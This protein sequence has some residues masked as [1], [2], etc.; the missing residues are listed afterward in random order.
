MS[1]PWL[2]VIGALP[3]LGSI[4]VAAL[5]RTST[6]LAKR[7]ALVVS[8]V[9]LALTVVMAL[10]FRLD[11]P[12]F[13]FVEDYP[14][15]PEFGVRYALGVDGVGLILIGLTV[16]LT[17][18]AIVAAWREKGAAGGKDAPSVKGYFALILALE[19]AVIGVFAATD[20]FVFYV[21]FEVM[22]VP[23][24]FMIGRYGGERRQYAAVK[25]FLYSLFGGM[26]MLASVIALA[27]NA[28]QQGH[29]TFA[30][31]ELT[32]LELSQTT[33]I[34]LFL[35]FFIAFAIKASLWPFHTWLPDAASEA[36][37][38]SA[39]LL[40]GVMDPAGAFGMIRYGLELFPDAAHFFTP[41]VIVLAVV[42]VLYGALAAIGQKNILRLLAY[43]SVSHFG[44]IVLG[45]FAMTSQSQTGAMFYLVTAGV[46]VAI[47]FLLAGVM[48]AR[49]G[50]RQIDDYGGVVKVAPVLGGTFLVA[51]LAGLALPGLATFVSEFL[52]LVGTFARYPVPAIIATFGIV[53]AAVYMLWLYQRTMTG[54]AGPKVSTIRDLGRREKAAVAPLI[55]LLLFLGLFPKP[56]LDVIDPAVQ[57]TMTRLDIQDVSAEG[58]NP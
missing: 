42:G 45:I 53:L 14:W 56:V 34:W 43:T 1:F 32:K 12:R 9:V 15:I 33:Q 48:V 16:V 44:I 58:N 8:V 46:A 26:L 47:Q 57:Q 25:F 13:Q 30:F 2:T 52:V 7:L 41:V 38:T 55:A 24:Y 17:P 19:T 36:R 21:L 51:C 23:M 22:L 31:S 4:V 49:H 5:P 27:V 29:S 35:G 3:L 39:I 10:Q 54:P 20:L 6:D 18:V 28:R 37:P 40:V 11:G 50:S